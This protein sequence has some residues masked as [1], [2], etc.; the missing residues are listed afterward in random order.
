VPSTG[1]I[2][3]YPLGAGQ[4]VRVPRGSLEAYTG[5]VPQWFPKSPRLL[6]CGNE[7]GKKTRCYAQD[8]THGTPTPL[9]P[10]GVE[11]AWIAQNERTLLTMSPGG[12]YEI[13]AAGSDQASPARGL[14]PIDV[15]IGWSTDGESVV[16]TTGGQIPARVE[17]VNVTT[18]ARTLLKELAP[19]DRAGLTSV[20]L[21]QWIEDGRGY[22]FRYQRSL[23]TLFAATG[24]R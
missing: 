9:T 15:P 11:H 6:V 19:P 1:E 7:K 16:V 2:L 8:I 12:S 13:R 24:V 20:V 22:V 3:L 23:S 18:G 21:E 17:R 5:D 4:T 10:E 14:T